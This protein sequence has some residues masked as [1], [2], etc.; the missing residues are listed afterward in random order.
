[1]IV[2]AIIDTRSSRRHPLGDAIETFIRREDAEKFIDEVRDD[3]PELA[4]YLRIEERELG[5][6]AARSQ[7]KAVAVSTH[8]RPTSFHG[9]DPFLEVPGQARVVVQFV[10]L[11]GFQALSTVVLGLYVARILMEVKPFF[12]SSTSSGSRPTVSSC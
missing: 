9:P 6:C 12:T 5:R 7:P 2:Y 3:D 4:S 10:F 1:V 11:L 8:S